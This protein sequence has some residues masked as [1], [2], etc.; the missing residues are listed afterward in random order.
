MLD[1]K[2]FKSTWLGNKAVYRTRMAIQEGGELIIIAPGVERFGE[3]EIA[4]KLIRKYGYVGKKRIM[5]LCKQ[6]NDLGSNLAVAC[7]MT[8]SSTEGRFNVRYAAKNLSESE[9]KQVGYNYMDY[10]SAIDI[11]HPQD[12]KEGF[13]IVND[14]EIFFI[15]NP[16][17]GLWV[18]R[19]RFNL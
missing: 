5:Q 9:L 7:H 15:G 6:N 12:L 13:N 17:I 1:E 16:T 19:K 10:K 11:Y 2:E 18:E 8:V 14:E 3:T 4:D